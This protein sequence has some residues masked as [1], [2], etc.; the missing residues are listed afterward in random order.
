MSRLLCLTSV[1]LLW[2][3]P[4]LAQDEC[5]GLTP[6][7]GAEVTE[8][9]KGSIEGEVKGIVSKLAGGSASIEGEYLRLESDTLKDYPEANKVFVWQSIIYLA[10]IRPDSG[11]D[12]TKLFELYLVGPP[13]RQ[14]PPGSIENSGDGAINVT[15]S[16]VTISR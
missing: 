4:G 10:C 11:L 15:G 9:F 12:L 5:A 8:T 13:E 3:V 7:G 2:T 14:L 1:A 6:K 16:N